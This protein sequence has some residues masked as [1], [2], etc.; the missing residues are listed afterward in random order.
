M[1]FLSG[2]ESR[3]VGLPHSLCNGRRSFMGVV[4][5]LEGLTRGKGVIIGYVNSGLT[6][7]ILQGVSELGGGI[8][9]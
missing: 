9:S 1:F 7:E 4:R 3:R 5:E 8:I 2:V 6:G